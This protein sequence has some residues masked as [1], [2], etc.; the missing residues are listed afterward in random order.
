MQA[1]GRSLRAACA[2]ADADAKG[3][4]TADEFKA[5]LRGWGVK[6]PLGGIKKVLAEVQGADG[7]I[8]YAAFDDT[9][10]PQ[11]APPP[12]TPPAAAVESKPKPKPVVDKPAPP[13]TP[14]AVVAAA[15]PARRGTTAIESQAG[16]SRE[17]MQLRERVATLEADLRTAN[18]ALTA[19]PKSG[20]AASNTREMMHLKSRVAE[21]QQE[22]DAGKQAVGRVRALEAE[23]AGA[24]AAMQQMQAE[25]AAAV[26]RAEAAEEQSAAPAPAD[27]EHKAERQAAE[28]EAARV[29]A[30]AEA[31]RMAAE[32]AG[33]AELLAAA[34]ARGDEAQRELGAAQSEAADALEALEAAR[35]EAEGAKAATGR[36]A[37]LSMRVIELED[38]LEQA[39][40]AIEAQSGSGWVVEPVTPA[41]SAAVARVAELEEQLAAATRAGAMA[42]G[43]TAGEIAALEARVS[44]LEVAAEA[45]AKVL[46]ASEANLLV[47]RTENEVLQAQIELQ[48]VEMAQAE[49]EV[50]DERRARRRDSLSSPER[51]PPAPEPDAMLEAM[52]VALD[53]E[54]MRVAQLEQDLAAAPPREEPG[55]GRELLQAREQIAQLESHADELLSELRD[56]K[57][58]VDALQNQL[59]MAI[60]R[61]THAAPAD[62]QGGS[63]HDERELAAATLAELRQQ[64]ERLMA[65]VDAWRAEERAAAE[66]QSREREVVAQLLAARPSPKKQRPRSAAPAA[67]VAAS[68]RPGWRPTGA[69]PKRPPLPRPQSRGGR[70][71]STP[72]PNM[73]GPSVE[74]ALQGLYT[75]QGDAAERIMAEAVTVDSG[76]C[77]VDPRQSYQ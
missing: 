36:E 3:H 1:G 48:S 25:H 28:A 73:Q 65:Q 71:N 57:E 4:L 31:A 7:N 13:R 27:E 12:E 59:F 38:E 24:N 46:A 5:A 6:L 15:E 66:A 32:A 69:H 54:R 2:A 64:H 58:E 72:S 47:A 60:E 68:S 50:R 63:R 29:A 10:A 14:P 17:A 37:E 18:A 39:A 35:A 55:N 76:R 43:S 19:R 56:S 44:E 40:T 11:A 16:A 61:G 33:L 21:L 74:L 22:A 8:D 52:R 42:M 23:V 30:E 9:A 67:R 34:E 45:Q 70:G 26:A 75:R 53:S 62:A 41:T 51:P 49:D 77:R 20:S